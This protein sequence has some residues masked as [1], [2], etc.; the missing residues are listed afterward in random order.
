MKLGALRSILCR[1]DGDKSALRI[2]LQEN[3]NEDHSESKK[4]MKKEDCAIR[5]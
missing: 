3:D 1:R 5:V 4:Y 2:K